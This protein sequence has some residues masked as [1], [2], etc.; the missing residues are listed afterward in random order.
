MI[1][2]DTNCPVV[3]MTSASDGMLMFAPTAA[4]LPSRMTTVPF[5]IVPFVAVSTVPPRRATTRLCA[6][7]GVSLMGLGAASLPRRLMAANGTSASNAPSVRNRVG[8]WRRITETS[9][10]ASNKMKRKE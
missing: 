1:P 2:G 8:N 7:C 5:G 10:K 3:S 9:G 4:I 6:A